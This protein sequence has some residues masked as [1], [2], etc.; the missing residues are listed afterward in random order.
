MKNFCYKRQPQNQTELR[1][2][3]VL[4]FENINKPEKINVLKKSIY[5]LPERLQAVLA[6]KGNNVDSKTC[7]RSAVNS[8]PDVKTAYPISSIT[9]TTSKRTPLGE[10]HNTPHLIQSNPQ[11]GENLIQSNPNPTL[12]SLN[13][14]RSNTIRQSNPVIQ[15]G[16]RRHVFPVDHPDHPNNWIPLGN[17][18]LPSTSGPISPPADP[19]P[20]N[21][22]PLGEIR[23]NPVESVPRSFELKMTENEDLHFFFGLTCEK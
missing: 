13:R 1:E 14:I 23:V 3:I 8:N 6:N 15:S 20:N 16:S 2:T 9:P 19:N 22:I 10:I 21:W 18:L 4:F 12:D 7:R 5:N 17:T 11:S